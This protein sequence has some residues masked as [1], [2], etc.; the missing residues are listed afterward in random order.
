MAI[1]HYKAKYDSIN[2]LN[3]AEPSDQEKLLTEMVAHC[4]KWDPIYK[5]NALDLYPELAEIF[6]KYGY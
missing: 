2:L 5:Y 4:R 1:W 3:Q 6:K